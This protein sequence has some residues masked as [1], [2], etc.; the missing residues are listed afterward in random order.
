MS[1]S[2]GFNTRSHFSVAVWCRTTTTAS[3]GCKAD[4]DVFAAAFKNVLNP[5]SLFCV[6]QSKVTK[7]NKQTAGDK[8]RCDDTNVSSAA[9]EW[10]QQSLREESPAHEVDREEEPAGPA[11]DWLLL[12]RVQKD[13]NVR[14]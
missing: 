1:K 5:R 3:L 8:G 10:R 4:V 2:A 11:L 14:M 7:K 13:K 12:G 9:L 6:Q